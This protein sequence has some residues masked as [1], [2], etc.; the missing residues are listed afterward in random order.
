[1]T[2]EPLWGTLEHFGLLWAHLGAL[3]GHFGVTL[4]HFGIIL[5]PFGAF[6]IILGGLWITFLNLIKMMACFH[7]IHVFPMDFNGFMNDTK[8]FRITLGSL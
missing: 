8:Q 5:A 7:E 6:G 1:M 2:L 4:G 3:W